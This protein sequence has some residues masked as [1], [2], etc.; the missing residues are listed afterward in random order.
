M[1]G[2]SRVR[3]SAVTVLDRLGVRGLSRIFAQL[4]RD[5]RSRTV[6]SAAGA[7]LARQN[8]HASTGDDAGAA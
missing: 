2:T 6:R 7:A 3:E 1:I 5:D 8:P 4:A